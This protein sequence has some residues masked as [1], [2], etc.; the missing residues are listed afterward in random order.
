MTI[1]TKKYS[2][3][4][5]SLEIDERPRFKTAHS[6]T[7]ITKQTKTQNRP[8]LINPKITIKIKKA[9]YTSIHILALENFAH[10]IHS[11]Q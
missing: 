5:Q 3:Q 1:H 10:I 8:T 11:P 7:H 4:K 2:I 9:S 6:Q